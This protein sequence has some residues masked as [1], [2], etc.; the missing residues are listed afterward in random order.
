MQALSFPF[1]SALFFCPDFIKSNVFMTIHYVRCFIL[2]KESLCYLH[3]RCFDDVDINTYRF[4]SYDTSDVITGMINV[5]LYTN[6]LP[7]SLTENLIC[8][9]LSSVKRHISTRAK[10]SPIRQFRASRKN[11]IALFVP[12]YPD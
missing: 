1:D 6:G 8:F 10:M 3:I 12:V 4:V 5:E 2:R 7:Y 9:L 11:E